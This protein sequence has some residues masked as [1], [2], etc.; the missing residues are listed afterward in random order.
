ML[1]LLAQFCLCLAWAYTSKKNTRPS[2]LILDDNRQ[3]QFHLKLRTQLSSQ[4]HVRAPGKHWNHIKE[5]LHSGQLPCWERFHVS[6]KNDGNAR[7]QLSVEC[8]QIHPSVGRMQRD[9]WTPK[10]SAGQQPEKWP[11]E[12]GNREILASGKDCGYRQWWQT[13][14]SFQGYWAMEAKYSRVDQ[15]IRLLSDSL[16]SGWARASNEHPGEQF[17]RQVASMD[18]PIMLLIAGRN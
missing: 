9:T 7:L 11:R 6:I 13:L 10:M 3:F 2:H 16:L 14:P 18:L 8:S 12:M 17:T 4:L 15:G 5:T 1:W